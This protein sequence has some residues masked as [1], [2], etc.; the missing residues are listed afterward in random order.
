M[1]KNFLGLVAVFETWNIS[2]SE[3]ITF[4]LSTPSLKNCSL[5]QDLCVNGAEISLTINTAFPSS[6]APVSDVLFQKIC[7]HLKDETQRLVSQSEK[8][9]WQFGAMHAQ[10]EQFEQFRIDEMARQLAAISPRLWLFIGSL[11]SSKYKPDE[12]L[13][14]NASDLEGIDEEI[15]RDLGDMIQELTDDK[16]TRE[17]RKVVR[18]KEILKL[19]LVLLVYY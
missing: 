8:Q 18:D 14:V 10:A 16:P 7:D 11:I 12:L 2:I 15:H 9:G 3:F 13:E 6:S 4:L 5:V 17:A 19:V 1:A